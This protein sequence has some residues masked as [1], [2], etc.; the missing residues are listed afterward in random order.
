M[1]FTREAALKNEVGGDEKHVGFLLGLIV[2]TFG[3]KCNNFFNA[4]CNDLS[5]QNVTKS[6]T[7]NVT[8]RNVATL[9]SL[10]LIYGGDTEILAF[11]SILTTLVSQE[12][13]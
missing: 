4:N 2:T 5:T 10:V 8:T 3:P 7:R 1:G 9:I 12:K 6:L 13:M 11:L